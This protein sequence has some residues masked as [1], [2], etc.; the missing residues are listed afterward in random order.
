MIKKTTH[1]LIFLFL[2]SVLYGQGFHSLKMGC[3]ARS[4]ALGMA[5]TAVSDDGAAGFWNPAGLSRLN[6]GDLIVS[7]HKWIFDT[8]S[9]FISAGW[10]GKEWGI[11]A[12]LLYTEVGNIELR[13]VPSPTP[14]ATFSAHEMILGISY[15]RMIQKRIWMGITLKGLYER[16]YIE[17]AAG[18]ALDIGILISL[19]DSGLRAGGVIQNIG[20]TTKMRYDEIDLPLTAKVGL[21]WPFNI[22]TSI[23]TISMDCVKEKNFPIHI[24][25]GIE[26]GWGKRVFIRIGYQTGYQI[27][28]FSTGI[29]FIWSSYRLDYSYSPLQS[30]FGDSHKISIGISL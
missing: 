12:Y 25:C 2:T 23:L 5:Y 10:G 20:R 16:I 6:K 26:Y 1:L 13:V 22:N 19:M 7:L 4:G 9:G 17:E 28:S 24:H 15:S 21:C 29:G 8:Q 27:R 30:E 14:I 11:G 3:D 18:C